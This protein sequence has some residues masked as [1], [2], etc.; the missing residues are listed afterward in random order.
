MIELFLKLIDTLP[1]F[2]RVR[3]VRLKGEYRRDHGNDRRQLKLD[4]D[5]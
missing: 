2:R 1:L 4:L 5:I 3:R